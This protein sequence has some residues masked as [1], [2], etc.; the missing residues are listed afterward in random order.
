MPFSA[1]GALW[2]GT[3]SAWAL[4]FSHVGGRLGDARVGSYGPWYNVTI[5]GKF[6][7]IMN[8]VNWAKREKFVTVNE[9]QQWRQRLEGSLNLFHYLED[10][11]Q[12]FFSPLKVPMERDQEDKGPSSRSR[13]GL[14]DFVGTAANFLFGVST[15]KSVEQCRQLVKE[16]RKE[17]REI[18]HRVNILT[19]VV[20]KTVDTLNTNIKHLNSI[21]HYLQ[22]SVFNRMNTLI[23]GLNTTQENLT[24]LM[25]SFNIERAVTNFERLIDQQTSVL[26]RFNKQ[27]T[28]LELG[29]LTDVLLPPNKLRH[30][31]A[32]AMR[33]RHLEQVGDLM[34][35]YRFLSVSPLHD[36]STLIYRVD[37]PLVSNVNFWLHHVLTFPVP[38]N[39]SGLSAHIQI[40]K[41]MI[42]LNPRSGQIFFPESCIGENPVVCTSGPL[43]KSSSKCERAIVT[44]DEKHREACK[45]L[46]SKSLDKGYAR[47]LSPGQYV[48]VS[49]GETLYT[50]CD[51]SAEKSVKIQAGTYLI[52]VDNGCEI[53]GD[54]YILPGIIHQIGKITIHSVQL[55]FSKGLNLTE[56]I[57]EGDA[58]KLL[59]KF[60]QKDLALQS[61]V[62]LKQ[63]KW[64]N[65]N[66]WENFI[67]DKQNVWGYLGTLALFLLVLG[68]GIF[69]L[70]NYGMIMCRKFILQKKKRRN[71]HAEVRIPGGRPSVSYNIQQDTVTPLIVRTQDS[72]EPLRSLYDKDFKF[73][74]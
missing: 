68:I 74:D 57:R 19:S 56:T 53:Q 27:R 66:Y 69:C 29:R 40:Q 52:N 41:E 37:L 72:I 65:E 49:W 59:K 22:E 48:I 45:V 58:L 2:W 63:I 24:K 34:W 60:D 14:F 70:K 28:S 7:D 71:Q 36:K 11:Q 62:P 55:N 5:R 17:S 32:T 43:Y 25:V 16:T 18:A 6:V 51:N 44:G 23:R 54:N 4:S 26:E 31:L 12:T 42:G 46:I 9:G 3:S 35:Y 20:N 61:I 13:R 10:A 38:Y 50:R 8:E 21:Q 67:P 39:S 15:D 30:I 33:G 73:Q 47:E 64:E 1:L